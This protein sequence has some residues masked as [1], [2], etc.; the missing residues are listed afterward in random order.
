VPLFNADGYTC[1][2]TPIGR[3]FLYLPLSG[4]VFPP[5][6]T[7]QLSIQVVI[8]NREL[9]LHT[10]N[11]ILLFWVLLRATGYPGRSFMVAA[12]FALHPLNVQSVAWI[13]ERKN[14]LSLMFLLLALGA[15]RWYVS[16]PSLWRYASFASCFVL[17]LMSK[18]QVITLP[19]VLLLWDYWPLQRKCSLWFLIKEKLPLLALCIPAAIAAVGAEQAE[20]VMMPDRPAH[21]LVRVTVCYARY[22]AKAFW[23]NHLAIVY[24]DQ[25]FATVSP[26]LLAT[27][28][29]LLI[30]LT[31]VAYRLRQKARY[32]CV[33][34]LWFLGTLVPMI[35]IVAIAN[36]GTADQHA[37][38]PLIGIFIA[39][40][41]AV[42]DLAAHRRIATRRLAITAG[43]VVLSLG[44]AAYRQVGYWQDGVTVWSHALAITTDNWK[45][46]EPLADA[47]IR[48]G[49]FDEAAPH[50]RI[51]MEHKIYNDPIF[52]NVMAVDEIHLGHFQ[53]AIDLCWN[54]LPLL[55]DGRIAPDAQIMRSDAL[56]C[57][58]VGRAGLESDLRRPN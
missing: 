32:L 55:D 52:Y 14:L 34:W 21:A 46:E 44:T 35:G 37:Y 30:L 8:Q 12:L 49:R 48:A 15:Y 3:P 56:L 51:P 2:F 41:W 23:P 39:V 50:M 25:L 20:N 31:A 33:G 26:V 10:L 54:T 42:A 24:P 36:S 18:P 53:H 45:A 5:S 28:A 47:L 13:A 16:R 40:C 4:G 7:I 1:Q 29:A 57:I 58:D 22:L 9:L 6:Q 38:L 27:S 11:V 17:G 19:F 43:I